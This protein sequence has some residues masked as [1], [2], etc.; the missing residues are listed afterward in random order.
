[1][2]CNVDPD[3]SYYFNVD[4][5]NRRHKAEKTFEKVGVGISFCHNF[6][7]VGNNVGPKTLNMKR[8][9]FGRKE[10]PLILNFFLED[11][12]PKLPIPMF[13]YSSNETEAK[14]ILPD[15]KG[16]QLTLVQDSRTG[17][18]GYIDWWAGTTTLCRSQLYPPVRDYEF[19][20]W[21]ISYS[22]RDFWG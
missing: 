15:C 17:P 7:F 22:D 19:G 12:V 5:K 16:I 6:I 11:Q 20:Y 14:F 8:I 1:M 21:F 3:Q 2:W 13:H 9:K 4:L 10:K 18:P